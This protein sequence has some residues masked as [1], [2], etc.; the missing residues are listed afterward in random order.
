MYEPQLCLPGYFCPDPSS[1]QLCPEGTYCIRGSTS[2][3]DCPPLS[4]CPAGTELRVFYGGIVLVLLLDLLMAAAFLYT[5]RV[6]EPARAAAKLREVRERYAPREG[7]AAGTAALALSNA[8]RRCNAGLSLELRFT[9]LG[10]TLPPPLS[11]TI[12]LGVSGRITPG[13]VT[14]IMGP[15]GAGKTTFLTVLMG[16]V[17]ARGG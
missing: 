12:L 2:P 14:A 9:Q 3:V 5:R 4:H 17:R 11:K 10:L 15:S 13:R 16:K 6:V 1:M 7:E 8:F